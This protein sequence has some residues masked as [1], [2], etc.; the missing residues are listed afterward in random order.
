MKWARRT[1]FSALVLGAALAAF[2]AWSHSFGVRYDLPL[3]LELYLAG[4]G[5]AVALSFAVMALFLGERDGYGE[6][7][8]YDL[9]TLPLIAWLGHRVVLNLFRALSVALFVL[10]LGAGFF[11]TTDPFR[12]FAPTFVWVVWWVGMAFVSTLGG[13]LWTL[14]NPWKILFTWAE[15][16]AGG[17]AGQRPYPAWLGN[18][19][20][21]VLFLVFAWLELISESG[22]Q[23]RILALLIVG[24][25][26][27]T[28]AGMAIYGRDVW[29]RNG[30]TFAV[31]YGLLARF[32]PTVGENRRWSLR[33]PAVGLLDARPASAS[34]VC[35]VLLLLTSVTFDGI[36]E[37]PLWA[38]TLE[39]IAESRALRPLLIFLQDSG[40]DLIVVI[41]SIALIAFPAI[42]VAV[43]LAFARMIAAAGGGT[44]ARSDVAGY[45][46]LSL[47]PIAI[48]YHLAHYISYLLIAGQNIVPLASDPFGRGWDL[49]GTASYVIDIGIV[50]AKFVWYV[51]VFAVVLGHVFAVYLA[52]VTAMRVFS[53]RKSALFSQIPMLALMVAYTMISLWILSQPIVN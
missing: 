19:P 34:T 49:F 32:A 8:R 31:A 11:G 27:I 38:G 20:A 41:K 1:I 26:A 13:N 22:E 2:P 17:F 3:P 48:A 47:I 21:L 18:W 5:V 25:S 10:L 42:F 39:W 4:A 46:V 6:T 23:P 45:F 40:V 52:H 9:L 43:Y 37:T 53:N 30:E 16:A 36:L 24:Y 29:L 33:L 35:F 28:W 7:L 12:N 44:V 51:A 15:W 14:V 50:N